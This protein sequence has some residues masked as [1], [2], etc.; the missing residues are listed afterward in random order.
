MRILIDT[1][2]IVIQKANIAVQFFCAISGCRNF[3]SYRG[4]HEL[5]K[6][7]QIIAKVLLL[8]E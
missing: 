1:P 5:V 8:V 4:V 7:S 3:I 6:N 2:K